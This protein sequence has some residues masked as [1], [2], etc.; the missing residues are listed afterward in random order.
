MLGGILFAWW[1]F[2]EFVTLIPVIGMLVRRI[3]IH[4]NGLQTNLD[5]SWFVNGFQENNELTPNFILV[6]FIVSTLACAWAIATLLRL[7]STRRSALFVA[8]IDLCF[9]GALIAG[10]CELRGIDHAN[11]NDF[12]S[13][14]IFYSLG[15]FGFYGYGD[16]LASDPNKNCS[17]L[18]ASWAFG[19]MNIIFFFFT[20]VLAVFMHRHQRTVVAKEGR[21]SRHSSRRGGGSRSGSGGRSGSGSRRKYYV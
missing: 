4:C 1:R 18:K 20:S 11:C 10:V 17:M 21:R 6:L 5:Q 3:S 7:G 13:S 16:G 14:P 19:I 8:F 12:P 2:V 15:P 9:F